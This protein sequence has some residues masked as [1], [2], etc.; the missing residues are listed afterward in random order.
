MIARNHMQR[1]NIDTDALFL[2]SAIFR[3]GSL[4][5]AAQECAMSVG[6]ASR[7]LAKL[8][9][10]LDDDL[11]LRTNR[12][13]VPTPRARELNGGVAELLVNYGRLFEKEVFRPSDV[14]RIFRILCV[15]NA[16]FTFLTPS[17]SALLEKAP[18]IGVEFRPI[19]ADFGRLLSSG[20]PILQSFRLFRQIQ[21]YIAFGL[22]M[23]FLFWSAEGTIHW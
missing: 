11:F 10:L 20:E 3:T 18:S 7:T 17:V 8:R 12:G 1:P 13:L 19:R 22:L 4:T 9:E 23:T 14:R 6:G 5:K 2:F 16:I 15:D 21:I